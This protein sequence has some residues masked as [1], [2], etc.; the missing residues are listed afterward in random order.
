MGKQLA[1]GYAPV[2]LQMYATAA[3]EFDQADNGWLMA[4][5]AFMRAVFLIFIFPRIISAGRIWFARL[6]RKPEQAAASAPEPPC[7]EALPTDPREFDATIG[8]QSE[9]EPV[10]PKPVDEKVAYEFDLFFLR[11][12]LVVDGALTAGAAFA[13]QGWHLYLGMDVAISSR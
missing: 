4:G 10:I 13:T 12:S 3:F 9:E 6:M 7:D 11:W 8:T 1:T 5:N 2:L